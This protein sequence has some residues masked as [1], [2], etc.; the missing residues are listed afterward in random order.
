MD[1]AGSQSARVQMVV[2]RALKVGLIEDKASGSPVTSM[3]RRS[4]LS[5]T[6]P[7]T[8]ARRWRAETVTG[9]DLQ[10]RVGP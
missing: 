1:S 9:Q 6:D 5:Q 4:G 3:A 10:P 7:G 8:M 2:I